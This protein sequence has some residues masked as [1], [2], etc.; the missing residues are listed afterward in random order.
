[1]AIQNVKNTIKRLENKQAEADKYPHCGVIL[2][3]EYD[4]L[5]FTDEPEGNQRRV[6]YLVVPGRMS[7]E[8]WEAKHG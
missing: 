4:K 3:K 1:M 2:Q 6:G 5:I 8:E 7:E